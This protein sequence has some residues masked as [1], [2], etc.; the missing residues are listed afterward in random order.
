MHSQRVPLQPVRVEAKEG[1]EVETVVKEYDYPPTIEEKPCGGCAM[2][3]P[4]RFDEGRLW[5]RCATR[6]MSCT[7][8]MRIVLA[9]GEVTCFTTRG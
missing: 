1:Q 3:I 2:F 9:R 8:T 5:G 4:D 7:S 6:N